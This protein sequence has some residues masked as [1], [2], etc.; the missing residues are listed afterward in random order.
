[1]SI[2]VHGARGDEKMFTTKTVYRMIVLFE[3]SVSDTSIARNDSKKVR[4]QRRAR[5]VGRVA[6]GAYGKGFGDGFGFAF[7]ALAHVFADQ[8]DLNRRHANTRSAINES[9]HMWHT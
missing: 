4:N 2:R 6:N 8:C 9:T 7:E 1:M 3:S 5:L